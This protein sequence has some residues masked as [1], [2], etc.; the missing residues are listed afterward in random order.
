METLDSLE[1][2]A[3]VKREDIHFTW[4]ENKCSKATEQLRGRIACFNSEACCW[5]P[6]VVSSHPAGNDAI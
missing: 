5:V 2:L 1:G 4:G 3:A 6:T